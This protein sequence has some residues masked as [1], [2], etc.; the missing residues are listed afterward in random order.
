MN[1]FKSWNSLVAGCLQDVGNGNVATID[2]VPAVMANLIS[3][4]LMFAGLTA[5]VMFIL[6]S[7]KLMNAGGDA[8]KI[9]GAAN[10]FTYGLLG[11][12]IVVFSFL[13]IKVISLVTG[14]KCIT[15]F[16]FGCS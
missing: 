16:G 14:V 8:K 3:A 11:L 7:I 13:I 2:C 1:F 5:L 9:S 4:L 12:A 10:N 6:G 15:S